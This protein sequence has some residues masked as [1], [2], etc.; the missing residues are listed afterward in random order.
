VS[1]TEQQLQD[2]LGYRRPG[3]LE[4]FLQSK[5][6]A[7]WRAKGGEIVTPLARPRKRKFQQLPPGVYFDRC[8]YVLR[9]LNGEPVKPGALGGRRCAAYGCLE[10]VSPVHWTLRGD[11]RVAVR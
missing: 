4:R 5:G 9:R 8:R 11:Y 1:I 7:Y 10:R 6:V 3:D 2:W